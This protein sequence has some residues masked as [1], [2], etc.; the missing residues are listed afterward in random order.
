ME[1]KER[2]DLLR[3]VLAGDDISAM[4]IPSTDPHFGE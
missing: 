4:I 3:K 2:L 1:R